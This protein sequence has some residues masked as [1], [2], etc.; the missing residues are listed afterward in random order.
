LDNL[1]IGSIMK[2]TYSSTQ[3][4]NC[5][6]FLPRSNYEIQ[7]SIRIEFNN[8]LHFVSEQKCSF[9]SVSETNTVSLVFHLSLFFHQEFCSTFF[10]SIN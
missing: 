8:L 1:L 2:S 6:Q 10:N 5:W 3:P 4:Y 7:T 9:I